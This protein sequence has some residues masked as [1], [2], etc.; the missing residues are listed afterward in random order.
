MW[1]ETSDELNEKYLI[2]TDVDWSIPKCILFSFR[3]GIVWILSPKRNGKD[4]LIYYFI[5]PSTSFNFPLNFNLKSTW[6]WKEQEPCLL[7]LCSVGMQ[8]RAFK[9]QIM[10][11]VLFFNSC[12][13]SVNLCSPM[14]KM[15]IMA[16]TLYYEKWLWAGSGNTGDSATKTL[17]HMFVQIKWKKIIFLQNCF[18]FCRIFR[19]HKR[20]WPLGWFLKYNGKLFALA[21]EVK[22]Y[23]IRTLFAASE[24]I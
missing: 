5:Y 10:D 9:A 13:F 17:R 23:S 2:F 15:K 11:K 8:R 3:S 24:F 4:I 7:E 12:P 6:F 19:K 16:K 18:R 22:G 20:Q 14:P 21:G 1:G